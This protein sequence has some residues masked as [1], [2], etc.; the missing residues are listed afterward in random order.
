MRHATPPAQMATPPAAIPQ[1]TSV[2]TMAYATPPGTAFFTAAPVQIP[3]GR[4][5]IVPSTV[6]TVSQRPK[7]NMLYGQK[8]SVVSSIHQRR[9]GSLRQIATG[10]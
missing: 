6:L 9:R 10:Q 1:T 4:V 8:L 7:T 5:V 3:V 2:S